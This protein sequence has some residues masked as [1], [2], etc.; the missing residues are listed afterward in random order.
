MDKY[1]RIPMSYSI[2]KRKKQIKIHFFRF[3]T[4]I[5]KPGNRKTFIRILLV[6]AATAILSQVVLVALVLAG[7]FGKLPL[8]DELKHIR[9]PLAS[10]IYSADGMLM[11]K[12]YIRNRQYLKPEEIPQGLVDALI[13]VE[14]H[15]FYEH[16]GIDIRSLG[17][18]LVKSVLMGDRGSG[19]GS[20]ITQ[21]LA[22]NLYPRR[23]HGILTMPVNKLKEMVTAR[24]IEQLYS[25]EEIL[26]LYLS[27]VPF[28]GDT[29]GIK[30]ASV[31]Y[32]NKNPEFL[33]LE[34]SAMLAGMLKATDLYNPAKHMEEAVLRRNVVL[35]LM[36]KHGSLEAAKGDSL[37]GLPVRLNYSPMP[38]FAGIAPYFREYL[39]GEL[40]QWCAAHLDRDGE[41]IDLYT[42]G[43][44]IYTTI[45]S[46]LQRYA[47][48]AVNVHMA[49]L[50]ELFDA[51]WS[52][53]DLW[54]GI[55]NEHLLTG[56]GMEYSEKLA[57]EAPRKM[58]VFTWEGPLVKEYNTL[59]SIRHY[60]KF[61]QA[62]FLAMDVHT[63]QIKAWVGGI[64]HRYFKWDHVIARRQA[65][66]TFKPLVYLAA[67]ENGVSPCTFYP[68][69]S[70]VYEDYDDWTPQNADDTYGG[71][72]SLKGALVHSVN[73]VSVALMMENGID[74][75]IGLGERAGIT[76][77]MP[78]VP[79]LALGSA[80]VSL[81]E[82]VGVYQAIANR[83]V[84]MD[85]LYLLRIE[86]KDGEVL[87]EAPRNDAGMPVFS[88]EHSEVMTEIL[89]NV[90]DHGTASALR[91]A[92]GITADV[93]GK[94]GTTQHNTDGWF[95]GFTPDLV[96]G[97]WVG[98]ELQQIR[99]REMRYGQGSF[100]AMPVWAGFM[101][102]AFRDEVWGFMDERQFMISDS[103]L[104][105]LDCEEF[106]EEELL[107]FRPL[108]IL[109]ERRFFRRLFRRRRE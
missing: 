54:K 46:R 36:V 66:S 23:N 68:N 45:D 28:G 103:V 30:S 9:N 31:R 48:E 52:G 14:D 7:A 78:P 11:G 17:R 29:Y 77:P 65:G 1:F 100:S 92:Y 42:D 83:G 21:Q 89:R 102:R 35:D 88:P 104:D 4:R 6:L 61:L 15:R 97:V 106:R 96:A 39:R 25:K 44:K 16:N 51:H 60:L 94:T 3:C 32:F 79:S 74:R 63:G 99:F 80:D 86:D 98:G 20:T 47:E 105:M 24:R 2:N 22:K 87:F 50:Q 5:R 73:T 27:T 91:N 58:E 12:Y 57:S 82:M 41:P 90:V 19:G 72:Y 56:T 59:D 38:H 53:G 71:Y 75:V 84:K 33:T 37:K 55:R 107:R 81:F 62:G 101:Q 34:E 8:R 85:P 40:E 10:E 69:D 76:S 64:S 108:E 13:A 49:R 18:V 43:L 67:L 95:I 70:V 93:A 109:K 26:V